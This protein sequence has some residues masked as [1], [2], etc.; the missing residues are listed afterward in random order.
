METDNVI[1]VCGSVIK[2][3]SICLL[4][5]HILEN[6]VVAEADYPYS[7]YYGEVPEKPQ[8]NSLFL[9]TRIFYTL[10]EVLRFNRQI[11]SCYAKNVDIA[12]SV[13]DFGQQCYPAIRIKNFPDYEHLEELQQCFIKLNVHFIRKVKISET[14]K[15]K[16]NKCFALKRVKD[17]IYI[18]MEEKDKGYI[19]VNRILNE[20]QFEDLLTKTRNNANCRLFDAAKCGIIQN[21]N[22]TEM[23]RIFSEKLDISMLECVQREFS[24]ILNQ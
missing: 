20:E 13:L 4:K 7:R 16:T 18:D 11:D 21:S 14:A 22:L 2:K 17:G 3:E 10:E 23:V 19:E 12:T 24:T 15:V 6:T 9:F 1:R 8:P 5:D